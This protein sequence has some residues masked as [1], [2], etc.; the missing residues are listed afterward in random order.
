MNW[1]YE[2][3]TSCA[4]DDNW[5]CEPCAA[6]EGCRAT[7]WGTAAYSTLVSAGWA[8]VVC[9]APFAFPFLIFAIG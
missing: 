1:S 7:T 6:A 5:A 3:C 4:V 8:L 9:S 2:P